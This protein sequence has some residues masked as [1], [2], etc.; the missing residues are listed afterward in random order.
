MLFCLVYDDLVLW[1]E[2]QMRCFWP[3]SSV[4]SSLSQRSWI[5]HWWTTRESDVWFVTTST[6]HSW[7]VRLLYSSKDEWL[8]MHTNTNSTV[9]QLTF[10]NKDW[11][12]THL[13]PIFCKKDDWLVML[14]LSL[15]NSATW[16]ISAINKFVSCELWRW[17]DLRRHYLTVLFLWTVTLTGDTITVLFLWTAT[18]TG[19]YN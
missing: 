14:L 4:L 3:V 16:Q 6:C 17:Q 12:V 1:L 13:A 10:C 7:I 9:Q 19:H 8:V 15:L 18:L 5:N 2:L 11:L